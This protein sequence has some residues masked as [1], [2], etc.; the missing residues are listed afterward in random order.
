MNNINEYLYKMNFKDIRW[1]KWS[2]CPPDVYPI[3]NLYN[4]LKRKIYVGVY[5]EGLCYII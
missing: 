1:M 4:I 5:I 2:A 3:E